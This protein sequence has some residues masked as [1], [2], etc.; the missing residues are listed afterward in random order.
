M[1]LVR[2]RKKEHFLSPYCP[3]QSGVCSRIS[4]P[5]LA[6]DVCLTYIDADTYCECMRVCSVV[7]DSLRPHGL[8]AYRAPLSREFSRQKYW[9]GLPFPSPGDLPNSGVKPMSLPSHALAGRLFT[10]T[11][12]EALYTVHLHLM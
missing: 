4:L 12:L 8:I 10:T 7:S 2:V 3:L 6:G 11:H 9:S 1:F 5:A